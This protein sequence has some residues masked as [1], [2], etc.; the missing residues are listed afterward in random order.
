L[1]RIHPG[2][3]A[4]L[5][6]F[7]AF[8]L[9]PAPAGL[10]A[11]GWVV[12]ALAVTMAILWISEA[13]PIAMTATLPFLILPLFGVGSATDVAASYASPVLFLVLGGAMVALAV[14]KAG[15]HRRI[16]LAIAR[17][18]PG[19]ER[20]V[21]LAFMAATAVTSM[22]V[23]NTATALIMLPVA[24]ALLSGIEA[25]P[26]EGG[27]A[28]AENRAEGLGKALVLGVAWAA[29]IGG[30]GTLVGSPT[31]AIAAGIMNRALGTEISFLSWMGYGI[32]IVLLAIPATAW[33]LAR[34]HG[35]SGKPI[36]RRV[37]LAALGDAGPLTRMERRLLPAL[38]LLFIGW[39]LLPLLHVRL[40]LPEVH[41]GIVAMGVAL[42]L[43]VLPD[44]E[45]GRLLT[46]ADLPRLP[47]DI[48]LLFGGG[49]A[50][51]EGITQSGLAAWSG[52]QLEGLHSLHPVLLAMI[53]V[54]LIVL[55]TE[56]ASNVATASGFI[57]VVAA[58]A[59][60]GLA[61]PLALAMAAALASSWG[62]MMPAGTPPNAIAFSSGRI[63]V[64]DLVKGGF[65]VNLMGIPLIVGVAFL[66]S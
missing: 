44:G 46:T 40:G 3:I 50:L 8:R 34:L 25:A 57:P 39:I 22:L 18:T 27:P 35:L 65:L 52:T 17:R 9:L 43:F 14:E 41:D 45:E 13:V 11:E 7:V 38:L 19:T 42:M 26:S 47:W 4:A 48:L 5:V 55:V 10:S 37:V 16:A 59:S 53:L 60:G 2:L 62:F 33:L 32:P 58:V 30:L 63:H 21:L 29:T 54:A 49:L 6:A 15:L 61:P 64:I 1:T 56:F 66:L 36:D 20:G 51:A 23:S 24:L 31:N 12:A 28:E